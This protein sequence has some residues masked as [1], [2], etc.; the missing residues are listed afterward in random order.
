MKKSTAIVTVIFFGILMAAFLN[1]S[2]LA[3]EPPRGPQGPDQAGRGPG[4]GF[5]PDL[6]PEQSKQIEQL[7][8]RHIR[9]VDL[10]RAEIGEKEA[11][12]TTLRLADE[13]D[14]KA[15][16]KTIDDISKLRGDIMKEREAHRREIRAL[17]TEAQK[18]VFDR[19]GPQGRFNDGNGDRKGRRG[20]AGRGYRDGNGPRP[21]CPYNR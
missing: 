20:K 3:Q 17:L 10:M 4:M 11:R 1:T 9:K 15:I 6:T 2:I 13:P 5:I 21:D 18:A 14:A 19:R 12:M 16:D 7:R 8:T